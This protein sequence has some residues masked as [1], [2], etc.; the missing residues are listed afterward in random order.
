MINFI[1][2]RIEEAYN[3]G[4]VEAGKTKYIAYFITI[5]RCKKYRNSVDDKLINEGYKDCIISEE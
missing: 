3:Y 4:G 5:S 2:R 1:T